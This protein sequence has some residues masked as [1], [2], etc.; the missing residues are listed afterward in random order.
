MHFYFKENPDNMSIDSFCRLWK[1]LEFAL[2]FEGK[3]KKKTVK[4]V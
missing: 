3:L 1:R 4:N 2:E